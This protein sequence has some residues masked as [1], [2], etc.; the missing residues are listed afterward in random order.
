MEREQPVIR[1]IAEGPTLA[2]D[3]N[4]ARKNYGRYAMTSKEVL[5]NLPTAKRVKVR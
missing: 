5:F 3:S 4:M 1:V 2:G